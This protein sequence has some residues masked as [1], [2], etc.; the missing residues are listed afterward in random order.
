MVNWAVN[1]TK[2]GLLGLLWTLDRIGLQ[3]GLDQTGIFAFGAEELFWEKLF[4]EWHGWLGISNP[5]SHNRSL[6]NNQQAITFNLT[7]NSNW[8]QSYIESDSLLVVVRLQ[9]TQLKQIGV[10]RLL[11]N[12]N[13]VSDIWRGHSHIDSKSSLSHV[14]HSCY[15]LN[16]VLWEMLTSLSA[17][18]DSSDVTWPSLFLELWSYEVMQQKL[19]HCNSVENNSLHWFSSWRWILS[20]VIHEKRKCQSDPIESGVRSDLQSAPIQTIQ[21]GLCWWPTN[22]FVFSSNQFQGF[23]FVS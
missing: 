14:A 8:L 6:T 17:I 10:R 23:F 13:N 21:S 7:L 15:F 9:G 5:S 20:L 1:K 4:L 18:F 11:V 22:W 3:I 2:I 16:C 19:S 12:E